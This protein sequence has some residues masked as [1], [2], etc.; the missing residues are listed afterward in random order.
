MQRGR[1]P[2]ERNG[3]SDKNQAPT[4]KY[5]LDNAVVVIEGMT[6]LEDLSGTAEAEP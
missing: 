1:F 3:A 6:N 4:P 5:A 2:I